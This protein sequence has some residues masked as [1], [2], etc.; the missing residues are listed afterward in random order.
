MWFEN[1]SYFNNKNKP[2]TGYY[3]RDNSMVLL[4]IFNV[5]S[6][7]KKKTKRSSL[8][9]W[10]Y[11][12]IVPHLMR[13]MELCNS[14]S[15]KEVLTQSETG[16]Y[17]DAKSFHM[18]QMVLFKPHN[19]VCNKTIIMQGAKCLHNFIGRAFEKKK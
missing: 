10:E 19:K 6:K 7:K 13:L 4:T 8:K 18:N 5:S 16:R 2:G 17:T 15:H 1:N 11:G 12:Q 9:K 14:V 3:F